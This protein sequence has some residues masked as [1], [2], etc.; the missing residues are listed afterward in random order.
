MTAAVVILSAGR[1]PSLLGTRNAVLR[2]EGYTVVTAV[3]PAEIVDVFFAGDYDVVVLC[4]T[5]PALERRKL[6][7]LVRNHAPRTPVVVLSSHDGQSA[8]DGAVR[9][10]N[11]P[12]E[13]VAAVALAASRYRPAEGIRP[14]AG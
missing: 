10:P 11:N 9:V 2:A 6:I 3:T 7:R 5:I 4:H 12:Q 14:P 1:D 13:L 8:D